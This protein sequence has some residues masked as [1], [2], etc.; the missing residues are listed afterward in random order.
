LRP[1][2]QLGR[3]RSKLINGHLTNAF[4]DP[5]FNLPNQIFSNGIVPL[6]LANVPERS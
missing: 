6:H 4:I 3:S 5:G 1:F 2:R